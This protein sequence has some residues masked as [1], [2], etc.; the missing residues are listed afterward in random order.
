ECREEEI[1]VIV[2]SIKEWSYS[3]GD[4]FHWITVLNRFDSILE[5]ICQSYKLKKL[6]A[7]NFNEETRSVLLA[8]LKFSRMLLENCTNRNLYSS[9]EHLNDLLYTSDLGVLE[10][11]LRLILRPAQRLSNQRALRTNFTISQERILTL[12]HSWGTKEYDIEMAQ[13]ASEE[14][15]IPEELTTLNYQFYRRLTPSEAAETTG[16]KKNET[17]GT[18]T[19]TPQKGKR[20]D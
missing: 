4:L 8:I 16:E 11:L 7:E 2:D 12:V 14:V 18:A 5:N 19:S 6:Q 13:L 20:K 17:A 9:Y 10:V 15:K 1:P 3:R